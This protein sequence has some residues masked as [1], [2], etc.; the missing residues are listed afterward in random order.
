MKNLVNLLKNKN[1]TISSMESCTGGL[2]ASEI[3]NIDGS[4]EIFK[5]GLVTYCNE[6][7]EYFGVSKELIDEYTVYSN[8]ISQEM[9]K[10]VS[11]IT[12]SDF[13]IGI[14]GMLG[15]KDPNNENDDINTVY[16]SIYEKQNDIYH[17]YKIQTLGNAR[18]EKKMYIVNYIKE[19]LYE[20]CK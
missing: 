19:K 9:A 5:L 4:S 3:T 17:N 13:G 6:Y 2:F 11:K 14:T 12:K 7:K 16:I 8:E 10:S 1:K 18:I 20:I 15:V